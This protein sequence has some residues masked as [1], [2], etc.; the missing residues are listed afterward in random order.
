M[1]AMNLERVTFEEAKPR[2]RDHGRFWLVFM[3]ALV[4]ALAL[5]G[6]AYAAFGVTIGGGVL[7]LQGA[8]AFGAGIR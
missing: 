5:T 2:L 4:V 6:L 3:L 8:L 1:V 7:L